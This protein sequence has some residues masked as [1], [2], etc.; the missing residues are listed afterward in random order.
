MHICIYKYIHT[1]KQTPINLHTFQCIHIYTHSYTKIDIH[2]HVYTHTHTYTDTHTH[3]T[4]KHTYR[5]R[6]TYIDIHTH[7]HTPKHK[8]IYI[9]RHT[10]THVHT[11]THTHTHI[12]YTVPLLRIQSLCQSQGQQAGFEAV[13]KEC[14]MTHALVASQY[15]TRND[16]LQ[17][18]NPET[19]GPY[20]S[21][22]FPTFQSDPELLVPATRPGWDPQPPTQ[23]CQ[24]CANALQPGGCLLRN[25]SE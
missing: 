9:Q 8:H 24:C 15:L 18:L 11:C 6:H 22:N 16:G 19:R 25:C 3:D 17:G 23:T 13:W 10:Y 20:G 14:K 2:I 12:V 1:E 21:P 4:H 7:I 5:Q